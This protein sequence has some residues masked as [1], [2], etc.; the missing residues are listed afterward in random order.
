MT[1]TLSAPAKVNL[2]LE[3]TDLRP[4]GYHALDTIFQSLALAD[5]LQ[6]QK[7]A[8]QLQ[9]CDHVG[10]G[11]SVESNP[12]NLVL[13][14]QRML[15][16]YLQKE[17]PCQFQLHKYL[18]AGGGLGGG[19]SDAATTLVG[20]NLLY[21]L[22]LTLPQLNHLAQK[23]GAD[24]A[25]NLQPGTA[26]G[27]DL[28]QE[29]SPLPFPQPLADW[30]VLLL[31]PPWGMSTPT[32]Y[33]AWDRLEADLRRPASA[34]APQMVKL[35]EN[36]PAPVDSPAWIASFLQLLRN[37][38]QPAALQLQPQLEGVF[39]AL[40]DWGCAATLLCGSGSTVMGLL[41]P[42]ARQRV[43]LQPQLL[44]SLQPLGSSYLTHF[45]S[46]R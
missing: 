24:V 2:C 41:E 36:L 16:E 35:L 33:Q 19:S 32:V 12:Q 6:L 8:T 43:E 23:L 46:E 26:R 29:I 45:I 30:G 11:L 10:Q 18:P 31:A 34:C 5:T 44:E 39:R 13:R 37:D 27:T 21:E 9:I 25:F 42:A 15:E 17:L 20:L 14:A 38:L 3:I 40:E 4:N 1:L 22:N 28:G 7:G